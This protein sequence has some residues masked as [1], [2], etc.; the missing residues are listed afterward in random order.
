M[1]TSVF[2]I[3]ILLIVLRNHK[4]FPLMADLQGQVVKLQFELKKTG[5]E[6]NEARES[7]RIL[8]KRVRTSSLYGQIYD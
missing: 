2:L 1:S 7:E 6:R 3:L 5:E 4:R 8:E